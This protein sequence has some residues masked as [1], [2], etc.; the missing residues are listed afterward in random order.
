MEKSKIVVC[1]HATV[2]ESAKKKNEFPN[3]YES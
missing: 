1:L 3:R 2:I